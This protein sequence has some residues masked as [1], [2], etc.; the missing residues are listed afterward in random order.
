MTSTSSPS[1]RAGST[2]T[3]SEPAACYIRVSDPQQERGTS[4]ETQRAG[5]L[6]YCKQ[7]RYTVGPEDVYY[8]PPHSAADL[9][10]RPVLQ[11]LLAALRAGRYKVMVVFDLDRISREEHHQGHIYTLCEQVGARL[12]SVTQDLSDDSIQGRIMRMA[13]GIYASIE[14]DK[15]RERTQRGT[16]ARAKEGH[17]PRGSVPLY[18]YVINPEYLTALSERAAGDREAQA[19]ELP[20]RRYLPDDDGSPTCPAEIVRRI[21]RLY[22]LGMTPYAI[23]R[24]LTLDGIPTPFDTL[25][26]RHQL[27]EKQA[28]WSATHRVTHEWWRTMIWRI[29]REDRYAGAPAH[30]FR[31]HEVEVRKPNRRTGE[32]RKHRVLTV[33]PMDDTEHVVALPADAV[34]ALVT[35][36]III[37]TVHAR[38]QVAK[39]LAARAKRQPWSQTGALLARGLVV[40]G[41]CGSRMGPQPSHQGRKPTY[42]C[43]RAGHLHAACAGKGHAISVEKLDTQV[44][45]LASW[46]LKHPVTLRERAA[47][48]LASGQEQADQQQSAL[49]EVQDR[50]N[51]IA[52]QRTRLV[53]LGQLA[54]DD[55]ALAE[56]GDQLKTLAAE[57]R[58]AQAEEQSL[59]RLASEVRDGTDRLSEWEAWCAREV[60][61]VE[62]AA[63]EEQRRY[64]VDLDV[65]VTVRQTRDPRGRLTITFFASMV[66]YLDAQVARG[67]SFPI[68]TFPDGSTMALLPPGWEEGQTWEQ[69]ASGVG[70]LSPVFVSGRAPSRGA[71]LQ[72]R[73]PP[74]PR[75][76]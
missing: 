51:M 60:A 6:E 5:V 64:L 42:A 66:D 40:C 15:I 39:A 14:R 17:L 30:A 44:W 7:R 12:E 36:P 31:N 4:P 33:R 76:R 9:W 24:Q 16:R 18:G 47:S 37:A 54:A 8:E 38:C 48:L 56:I 70:T 25:A 27:T 49:G 22:A 53:K 55:A 19:A 52:Q 10:E 65:R 26:A 74:S 67:A 32:F 75:Y 21:W 73:R 46:L 59:V 57:E 35:D 28:R 71:Q 41:Y 1:R 69:L 2:T 58:E 45:A 13:S 63:P 11:R 68:A 3:G 50:L 43:L 29:L 20:K 72:T 34:P 62:H 61:N 23:A